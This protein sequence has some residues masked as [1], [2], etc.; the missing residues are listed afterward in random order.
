MAEIEIKIILEQYEMLVKQFKKIESKIEEL[1][2]QVPGASEMLGIKGIGVIT[3]AT[4]IAEVGDITRYEHPKQIQKLAGYNLVENS[5]GQHK[6]QTTISKRG[7]RRLRSALYKMIMPILANNKEFQELHKYY[8]TRKENPL[9]K[10]Q[11]MIVLC[12]KLIRVFFV[13]LKKGVKYNGNKMLRDIKR[14]EIRNA[15]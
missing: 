7:R 12:C 5:S 2:M 4:F 9:K 13:I 1:F 3:A 14:P 10:K 15:A 8:T 6:G 11:S